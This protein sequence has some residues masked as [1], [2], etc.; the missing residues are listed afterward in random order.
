MSCATR[1]KTACQCLRMPS[2][3]LEPRD[4]DLLM[5]IT[6]PLSVSPRDRIEMMPATGT[7]AMA[8]N[9]AIGGSCCLKLPYNKLQ[10]RQKRVMLVPSI[11]VGVTSELAGQP[12]STMASSSSPGLGG[13]A[14]SDSS[15]TL[16]LLA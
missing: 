8:A 6:E 11:K 2:F 14:S 10:Y 3:S 12:S 5:A 13:V 7:S 15:G 16:S 1:P 4:C 9:V